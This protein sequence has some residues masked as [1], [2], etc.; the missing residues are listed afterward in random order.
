MSNQALF[1]TTLAGVLV[2]LVA[3]PFAARFGVP[4]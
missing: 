4:V 2:A 1:L 3:K